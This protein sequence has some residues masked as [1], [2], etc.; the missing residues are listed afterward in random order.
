M[1]RH[2]FRRA[3]IL[4]GSGV[5]I[6]GVTWFGW[7]RPIPV[8][9]ATVNTA[10]MTV[11][12]DEDAK[13]R[14]R[15]IYTVSAPVAGKVLRTPYHV[16]DPVVADETVVATMEP[17][18]PSFHDVR[19]HEELQN[20]V[21]AA[22]AAVRFAEAEVRRM[23]AALEFA[24]SE[25]RRAQALARTDAIAGNAVDRANFEVD[26]SEAALASAK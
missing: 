14:V 11:T 13:T 9:L 26:T 24:R 8:D 4:L 3:A 16:G 7:P 10:P 20:V 1:G 12:V 21:A 5:I 19:T 18:R 2:W 23:E 17:A 15:H 22:D 6:A 25:L